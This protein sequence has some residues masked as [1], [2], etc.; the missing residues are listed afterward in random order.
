MELKQQDNQEII[1]GGGKEMGFSIDTDSHIIFEILRSKMYSNKIGAVARE[2][3][4]NSRDAH[5]EAGND[6]P[7]EIEITKNSIYNMGDTSIIFRD[8][9]LGISSDRMENIF[10]KY[11]AS[12]KRGDNIQTGGFGLGAKTPFAYTDSFIIHTVS[13][14]IEYIYNA[15]IDASGKGKMVLLHE[16]FT[17]KPSGTEIIIPIMS[18]D[19]RE[20]F[21]MEVY[22]A[23]MYW[24]N[25]TYIGFNRHKTEVEYLFKG[26]NYQ[27]VASNRWGSFIG[28]LD[29]I[30]YEIK[31]TNGGSISGYT[32]LF[33]LEIGS[34]TVNANR[35]SLQYDEITTKYIDDK[36]KAFSREIKAVIEDYLKDNVTY[37]DA[38]QKFLR[39]GKEK[40]VQNKLEELIYQ[41]KNNSSYNIDFNTYFNG[42]KVGK[43]TFQY[44]MVQRVVV[45]AEG[46]G[47]Y[48]SGSVDMSLPLVY[49]DKGRI[50][51]AKNESLE[52]FML[53]TPI[54]GNTPENIEK[55]FKHLQDITPDIILYSNVKGVTVPKVTVKKTFLTLKV[56]R[57]TASWK[58]VEIPFEKTTKTIGGSKNFIF[59]PVGSLRSF[60]S[61]SDSKIAL[62]EYVQ[63]KEIYY[64]NIDTYAKHLAPAGFETLD[65]AFA[66]IDLNKFA[67]YRDAQKIKDVLNNVNPIL[68]E[69]FPELLPV[70]YRT[71]TAPDIT[72]PAALS[73]VKWYSLGIPESKFNFNGLGEK[74]K[75]VMRRNYPMVLPYLRF[76]GDSVETKIKNIKNY[77]TSINTNC[78][79]R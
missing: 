76:S 20:K 14:G 25:V 19:D 11:A 3:A 18:N 42:E 16:D 9:G 2:V 45:D 59:I 21:E 53:I 48:I 56:R 23:T 51:V 73:S 15:I 55:E 27:I 66:K 62:V 52:R 43:L 37:K 64:I 68:L 78:N 32:V 58:S 30:P 44:H 79:K 57:A 60:Y 49:R 1:I 39:I 38:Y 33:N 54:K 41:M 61:A 12:T 63:K 69:N 5:R 26:A 50:S 34:V 4:S 28:L 22:N 72:P 67:K 35:E 36:Y 10:M 29:G 71:L 24:G 8:F 40:Q 13:D 17:D 70:S 46:K 74:Y 75:E 47:K 65:Q 77:V 7:I 31:P 6:K